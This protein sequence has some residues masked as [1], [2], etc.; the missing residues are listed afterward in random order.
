MSNPYISKFLDLIQSLLNKQGSTPP[1]Q[2]V[3]QAAPIQSPEDTHQAEPK[4]APAIVQQTPLVPSQTLNFVSNNIAKLSD[5]DYVRAAQLL[6]VEVAA[7]RAVTSVE[8]NG[9]GFLPSKRPR[10][11]FESHLFARFTTQKYNQSN[12]NVSSKIWNKALYKGGEKEYDRLLE[13]MRLNEQAALKS[14]SYGLFQILGSNC[15]SC[16]HDNVYDFVKANV[17]S[18]AQQLECFIKFLQANGL[19]V[20]LR[21]KDWNAFAKKYN[22]PGYLQNAYHT[23]LQ[24]AYNKFK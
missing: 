5:A 17:E 18:E 15:Q 3:V 6:N 10:I 23:K 20:H 14:A 16:G 13:A 24:D 7:I 22:G 21:N 11:L 8:S 9:G 12:P 1:T 2:P 4:V 19:D